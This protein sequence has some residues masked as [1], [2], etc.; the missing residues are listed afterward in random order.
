MEHA[1]LQNGTV[2]IH[3]HYFDDMIPTPL[4]QTYSFRWVALKLKL[5]PIS[6]SS[7]QQTRCL[8]L[9]YLIII[10]IS[11]KKIRI[12]REYF[13]RDKE[14]SFSE[15]ISLQ[16]V[17]V[18]LS[19]AVCHPDVVRARNE[20]ITSGNLFS[21]PWTCT[22]IQIYRGGLWRIFLGPLIRRT[23]WRYRIVS[24]PTGGT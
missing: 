18:A 1:I 11:I 23:D 5:N 13:L 14:N 21:E 2:N 4:A 19:R 24:W 6:T 22:E 10:V 15:S 3:Q 8:L 20:M 16:F 12:I 9:P 17:K 7:F